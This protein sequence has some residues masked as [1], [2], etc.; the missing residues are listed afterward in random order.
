MYQMDGNG[1]QGPTMSLASEGWKIPRNLPA[2]TGNGMIMKCYYTKL[3]PTEDGKT[4][5][6]DASGRN[7]CM[8]FGLTI[9][10]GGMQLNFCSIF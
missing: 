9:S 4:T 7:I 3:L 8:A 6:Y 10:V 5:R 2:P 1:D